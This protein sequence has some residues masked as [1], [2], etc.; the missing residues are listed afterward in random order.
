VFLVLTIVAFFIY[1]DQPKLGAS[2]A[3]LL[4]FFHGDRTRI[5]IATVIFCFSFL[6]LLWFGRPSRG[7]CVMPASPAGAPRR[8][9]PARHWEPYG[10]FA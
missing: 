9:P 7:C 2:P 10:S 6:E 8:Q 1:G 3:E 4:S 5:L